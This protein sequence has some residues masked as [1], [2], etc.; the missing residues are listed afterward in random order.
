MQVPKFQMFAPRMPHLQ[1]AIPSS[2]F[3]PTAIAPSV[4]WAIAE[5][6]STSPNEKLLL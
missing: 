4:T 3:P 1:S 2:F 6:E 5:L